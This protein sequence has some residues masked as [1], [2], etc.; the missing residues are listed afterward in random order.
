M[1]KLFALLLVVVALLFIWGCTRGDGDKAEDP[2]TGT[3]RVG[4]GRR[5]VTPSQAVPLA[6]YSNS[7][8]RYSKN[9]LNP[10]C[11][12]AVAITDENENTVI[13]LAMDNTKVENSLVEAT[14]D[15]VSEALGIDR[16]HITVAASHSHSAVDIASTKD[17]YVT[18]EYIPFLRDSMIAACV[19]AYEDRLPAEMYVGSVETEGMNFVR[20]YLY[21][22]RNGVTHAFSDNY[23][24]ATFNSTTRHETEADTTMHLLQFK[25]EGGKDI[26]LANWRA[27]PHL[28]DGSTATDLSSDYIGAFRDDMEMTLDCKFIYFQGA[29]GNLNSGSRF[30]SETRTRELHAYSA[31]LTEY[32]TAGLKNNMTKVED[33]TLQ[34][35]QYFYE[36]EYKKIDPELLALATECRRTFDLTGDYT[37]AMAVVGDADIHSVYH[38]GN[39]V[40]ISKLTGTDSIEFDFFTFG[41]QVAVCVNPHETFDTNSMWLEE[42][43]PFEHTFL[44][45]YANQKKTY[46]PSVGAIDYGCYEADV[47]YW[48][49]GTA[50]KEVQTMVDILNSMIKK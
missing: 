1:K 28:T 48:E 43:S 47:T 17:I 15:G 39:F 27:H 11:V 29:S 25:R 20:Q 34:F 33:T 9:F 5:D 38:A 40:T 24:T 31:I 21:E 30:E 42:N 3:F 49:R 16:T 19:E 8:F 14:R 10:V 4:Y 13:W 41:N 26:V 45:A 35:K 12:S 46:T 50:E 44:F 18:N 23:G 22:D 7:Q 2:Y 37:A 32:A 36:A 6:G